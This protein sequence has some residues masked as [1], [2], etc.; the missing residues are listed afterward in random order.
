MTFKSNVEPTSE[1]LGSVNSFVIHVISVTFDSTTL[2]VPLIPP[3][4]RNS[5]STI[6][7]KFVGKLVPVMT[8]VSIPIGFNSVAGA[9]AVMVTTTSYVLVKP[10]AFSISPDFE[11]TFGCHFPPE[12]FSGRSHKILVSV[13]TK[14]M[15]LCPPNIILSKSVNAICG[16][17]QTSN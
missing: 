7:S 8:I 3:D 15:Q 5:I 17:I 4:L 10:E 12:S 6:E 1:P 11:Y 16:A 13:K 14:F 9:T 2:Q